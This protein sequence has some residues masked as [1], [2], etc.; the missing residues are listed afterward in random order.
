[1][2]RAV[3]ECLA[4][5][6]C[7]LTRAG[8]F[9]A[10][11]GTPCNIIWR[12][13]DGKEIFRVN[14]WFESTP[15]DLSIRVSY[16]IGGLGSVPVS[17]RIGLVSV[18]CHMGGAKRLFSCPGKVSESPCGRRARKLYLVDGRWV[19]CACGDLMYLAC[20]Q[21]DKRKDALLRD[22]TAL[23]LALESEDL[24]Q[25]FLGIGAYTQAIA[26][27]GKRYRFGKV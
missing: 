3:E 27:L 24:K 14:F 7:G 5:D 9:Q 1:M 2:K 6:I 15:A 17:Y 25:R 23:I 11:V 26:R 8:A 10:R 12:D 16:Q 20:R 18:P 22:P 19:C 21:H 4:W 13:A